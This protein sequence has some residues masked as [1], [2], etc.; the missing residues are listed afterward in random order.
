MKKKVFALVLS[1]A[2]C[3]AVTACGDKETSTTPE[4]T[5]SVEESIVATEDIVDPDD[6]EVPAETTPADD[7]ESAAEGEESQA[8]E[9]GADEASA[10]V[11]LKVEIPEGFS[12]ISDG[13]YMAEDGANI[14]VLTSPAAGEIPS[15]DAIVEQLKVTLGDEAEITVDEY[16]VYQV[17]GY[18]AL[19][20]SAS[21]LMDDLECT[22]T[23][24]M[25]FADGKIGM[26][27]FTQQKGGAW[28]D[29]FNEC[30]ANITME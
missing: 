23:Q 26:A 25:V 1:A 27:A 19:R 30:I 5:S 28:T 10:D 9:D 17:S 16:E 11:E 13:M 6:M 7:A 20:F 8:A 2:M 14:I 18:D 24:C 12:E 3:F 4:E 29:A 15:Q 22:Q 21:Y